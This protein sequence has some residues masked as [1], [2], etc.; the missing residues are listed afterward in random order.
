MSVAVPAGSEQLPWATLAVNILGAVLLGVLSA[1]PGRVV[2]AGGLARPFLGAGFCG[3][4]TTFSTLAVE[5]ASRWAE[6]PMLAAAYAA[7]SVGLAP[8]AAAVGIGV[9]GWASRAPV[10]RRATGRGR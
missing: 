1:L 8:L 6:R 7:L 10:R 4:L 3:G 2:P 5:V 9:A